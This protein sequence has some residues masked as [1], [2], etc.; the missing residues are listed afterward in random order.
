MTP[1]SSPKCPRCGTAL[2]VD[3]PEGL[4]PHCL[5]S[6]N[7][8]PDPAAE[9]E[10]SGSGF[11][12][13]PDS[14]TLAG[15]FPQLEI[16]EC[17]GRGGMGVVYKARQRHMDRFVALKIL[18]P[19]RQGDI[20]FTLRFQREARALARLSHPNIVAVH[21]LGETGGFCYLI[22]EFV[23]GVTLRQLI[24]QR[25]LAPAEAL[26]IVPQICAAL[27]Y[28]HARGVVHR[29]IKPENI[30]IASDGQVKIADFGIAKIVEP[31]PMNLDKTGGRERL[32][33]PYYMAPEQAEKPG[34]VDHRADIFSLGVVIYEM[35]TG[36]LPLGKFPPPSRKVQV[37]VRLDE[38]VLRALEK[39]PELRYQSAG[40]VKTDLETIATPS[41]KAQ[42]PAS[43]FRSPIMAWMGNPLFWGALTLLLAIASG[44]VWFLQRHSGPDKP[45]VITRFEPTTARP[46]EMVTLTGSRFHSVPV[47]NVVYFGAV[48][49]EVISS[50]SKSMTVKVPVG[51]TYAP[52]TITVQGLTCRA[53]TPFIPTFGPASALAAS[54]TFAKHSEFTVA[55]IQQMAL[56]GDLNGDGKPD[57][58]TP[59]SLG[60]S[61]S[62][63]RSISSNGTSDARVAFAPRVD[64]PIPGSSYGGVLADLDGDGNLDIIAADNAAGRGRS[65]SVFQN[66]SAGTSRENL[67]F[68]P[69][70]EF[71]TA[72]GPVHVAADDLDGDGRLELIL[73][74]F[75]GGVVSVLQNK[76]SPGKLDADSF[77]RRIDLPSGASSFDIKIADLDGDGR[78]DLIV[79]KYHDGTVTLFR[80]STQP[81]KLELGAFSETVDFEVGIAYET[82]VGDLDG[83][84]K[85]DL[86]IANHMEAAVT[87][88]RNT[89]T[90]GAL[91]RD[92]FASSNRFQAG[93]GP[94]GIAI[95]DVTGDGRP[96]LLTANDTDAS[97]TVL[98]NQASSGSISEASFSPPL[99]FSTAS[100]PTGIAVG[101]LDGDGRPEIVAS[102]WAA[103]VI[104]ILRNTTASGSFTSGQ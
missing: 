21:D 87:V 66:L 69:R 24:Q 8:G 40:Q 80:N 55:H 12:S 47:S 77:S 102:T 22:M 58:V 45:P 20:Q 9:G 51:A 23:A 100:V 78:R 32:G 42:A 1:P 19:E 13:Q 103:N 57:A 49:A 11:N 29:D 15:C 85:L 30:L 38:I 56:I 7:L 17:L 16:L 10:L 52:P 28:A 104:S 39:E 101:D 43:P 67:A 92:S 31:G 89:G 4:C 62:I 26:A 44:S 99:A 91:T 88:L 37:D 46:G 94:H 6:L 79:T 59:N 27:Q 70:I 71:Q 76:S 93:R 3:A 74:C 65:V 97:V 14:E 50:S 72:A 48:R 98:I 34:T 86:A 84:G 25:K 90:P 64:I 95:A 18:A 83:D 35:L 54:L 2:P 33:T 75:Q 81:G 96:D 60:N 68:S 73:A 5:M 36:E 82:A 61:V 63:L 41:P 53:A